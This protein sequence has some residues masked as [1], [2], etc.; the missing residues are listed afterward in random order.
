MIRLTCDFDLTVAGA[1][2]NVQASVRQR[3]RSTV[4]EF[5]E[6]TIGKVRA[7]LEHNP[8]WVWGPRNCSHW[9]REHEGQ[10]RYRGLALHPDDAMADGNIDSPYY[11]HG[12]MATVERWHPNVVTVCHALESQGLPMPRRVDFDEEGFAD[13]SKPSAR[14]AVAAGVVDPRQLNDRRQVSTHWGT[15]D[16]FDIDKWRPILDD[17]A[18]RAADQSLYASTPLEKFGIP[19]TNYAMEGA[20]WPGP[21]APVC[22]V[23]GKR[24]ELAKVW[25]RSPSGLARWARWCEV[26]IMQAQISGDDVVPW[27]FAPRSSSSVCGGEGRMS[28]EHLRAFLDVCESRG[29]SEVML[30]FGTDDPDGADQKTLYTVAGDYL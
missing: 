22:Y 5:V 30:W 13:V 14:A 10:D 15:D 20:E 7:H 6:L 1:P 4:E 12:V 24:S 11:T 27:T 23:G 28:A 16:E 2:E 18:E 19:A 25:D 17:C 21:A 3:I 26:R 29:V 8:D 9:V